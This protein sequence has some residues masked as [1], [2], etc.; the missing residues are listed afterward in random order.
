M[1]ID[2]GKKDKEPD[3]EEVLTDL[4]HRID[5]LKVL[6]EQ[7]FMG[8]EKMEPQTARK[9][10]TRKMLELTQMN[11][12]N[13]A[14]RYR[15]TALNQQGAVDTTYCNRVL[16]EIE[17]GTYFRSIARV[18]REALRKGLE[19]P[20]EVFRSMPERMR[21]GILKQRAAV[22]E[23]N[24]RAEARRKE[25][26]IKTP[27]RAEKQA[28]AA[29][30]ADASDPD[31]MFSAD[32]SFDEAFDQLF[33]NLSDQP[34][35]ATSSSPTRVSDG[36]TR[37]RTPTSRPGAAAGTAPPRPAPSLPPGM[38]E[39]STKELYK[40]YVQA[41]KL[42]GEDTA[43]LKY[44]HIVHTITKQAPKI[45]AQHKARGVEFHVVIRDNKVILKATPKK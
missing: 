43:S 11:L 24:A 29:Q 2:S 45:M 36:P 18:G 20:D 32:M 33:D 3:I 41:K 38:D 28:A 8:I 27:S 25:A 5:R 35:G 4:E 6:Y 7:Y 26:G 17:R 21:E 34:A 12:R 13:T 10:V 39:S 42:V 30:G 31:R 15:Y 19:I 22:A 16:R 1:A 37:V 44:E 14:L 23:R 9:E 40:R